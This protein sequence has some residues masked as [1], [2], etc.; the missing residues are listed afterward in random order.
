[1]H[2]G[3]SLFCNLT[4]CTS[5]LEF[6]FIF[7]HL[8]FWYDIHTSIHLGP[9]SNSSKGSSAGVAVLR[10]VFI[11]FSEL[12]NRRFLLATGNHHRCCLWT[13]NQFRFAGFLWS[14]YFCVLKVWYT[15]FIL[16]FLPSQIHHQ[17]QSQ[18]ESHLMGSSITYSG[19][20][21]SE[22]RTLDHS[23]EI[24]TIPVESHPG[25]LGCHRETQM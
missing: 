8:L 3:S 13:R 18:S 22:Y 20:C 10:L 5:S 11:G 25:M 4:L 1:M 19:R 24:S 21:F 9:F 6:P 17:N 23:Q 7:L 16:D 15:V 14:R 2:R 12:L